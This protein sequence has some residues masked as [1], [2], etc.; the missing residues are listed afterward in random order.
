MSAG[1]TG[2]YSWAMDRSGLRDRMQWVTDRRCWSLGA[3]ALLFGLLAL[4]SPSTAAA[5]VAPQCDAGLASQVLRTGKPM[6]LRV[7]CSD[8]D[9]DSLTVNHSSPDHGTL[10]TFVFNPGANAYEATF[11]PAASYTG[12]DDFNF[13]ASDGTATTSTY[14]FNLI[15]TENH[16]PRCEPNGAV[17]TKVNQAVELNVFCAD[18][19]AQDQE[20]TYTTVAGQGPDH[21]SLGPVV[22]LAVQYT[23]NTNFSGADHFTI[24]ASDGALADSYSQLIHI[25]NTPLCTT[26]PAV[27]IRSGTGRF[28]GIDC[29]RPDDDTGT[30]RYEI[31][32]PPTKGTVSPSGLTSN[33]ERFYEADSGASGA[34]SYT[35]RMTSSS[36]VSPYVTQA[37]ATGAGINHA[38]ECDESAFTRE[39]V[40]SDR[41]RELPIPCT[42][43][44][45]DPITYAAG[46]NPEHGTSTTD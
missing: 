20:L 8:A 42:D 24:R 29:T 40:Y 2:P 38:P 34:D 16:A 14:G 11:T 27:Q 37:I 25:A 4:V 30:A 26:P 33:P 6:K 21:G 43:V 28:L 15:I 36:G 3:V 10:G 18:Q 31:G 46:A 1:K 19:D 35:I 32:T 44:D 23:P 5:N 17:H 13:T 22:D 7:Y 39:F 12:P 41:A 9:L 45:D